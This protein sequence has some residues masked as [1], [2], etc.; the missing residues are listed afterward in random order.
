M[1]VFSGTIDAEPIFSEESECRIV[2]RPKPVAELLAAID[3]GSARV[4]AGEEAPSEAAPVIPPP[5]PGRRGLD[6]R[7]YIWRPDEGWP[8]PEPVPPGEFPYRGRW[9]VSR[10]DAG[11]AAGTRVRGPYLSFNMGPEWSWRE[12][13]TSGSLFGTVW[14]SGSI[15]RDT[16]VPVSEY[17]ISRELAADIAYARAGTNPHFDYVPNG[18]V[19]VFA[20]GSDPARAVRVS[21]G[22]TIPRF[23]TDV[24]PL[25]RA[26]QTEI[27]ELR[28]AGIWGFNWMYSGSVYEFSF[29]DLHRQIDWSITPGLVAPTGSWQIGNFNYV[30]PD[31]PDTPDG[32]YRAYITK[33]REVTRLW[34]QPDANPGTAEVAPDP[35]TVVPDRVKGYLTDIS[36]LLAQMTLDA[37]VIRYAHRRRAEP[38]YRIEFVKKDGSTERPPAPSPDLGGVSFWNPAASQFLNWRVGM[39]GLGVEPADLPGGTRETLGLGGN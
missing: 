1:T 28:R 29:R 21:V 37:N 5:V 16:P 22:C 27:P 36:I 25:L 2:E 15:G 13:L 38:V 11:A 18:S 35:L 20:S 32:V 6:L 8:R 19:A 39:E 26:W 23:R 4:V 17:L 14:V 7:N 12:V 34:R 3:S 9:Y 33:I 10:V 30:N 31:Q 24:T